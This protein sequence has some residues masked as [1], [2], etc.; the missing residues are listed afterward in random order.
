[1]PLNVKD[2][3]SSAAKFVARAQ[4]A[5]AAYTQGVQGAGDTWQQHTASAGDAFAAGVNAAISSGRFAKGVNKAGAAKY[6]AAAAGKGAQR[7]PQ[8]VA[9]A[10]PAWQN[11]VAPYLQMMSG[12]TLPPRMPRGDPGNLQRVAAVANANRAL[13]L[14]S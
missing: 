13:K 1:M 5:G 9:A 4:A 14:K 3:T 6:V 12:L 11:G 7:Y 2:A 10:G 8:G